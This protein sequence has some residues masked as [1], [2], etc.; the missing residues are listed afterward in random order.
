MKKT[1]SGAFISISLIAL[2]AI[3]VFPSCSKNPSS[4][5]PGNSATALWPLKAGNQWIYVDS[6]FSDTL[7]SSSNP[8]TVTALAQTYHDPSGFPL[9]QLTT[10]GQ[11]WFYNNSFAGVDPGN[12]AIFLMDTLGESS[13][14]FFATAP[15]D[16]T[17]VGSGADYTNPTCPIQYTQVGFA[18]T[19]AIGDYNCIRN[20]QYAT[21]CNGVNLEV[22]VV[23][24][25]PGVGVVRIEDYEADQNNNLGLSYSQTLKSVTLAK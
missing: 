24:V 15:Q 5:G 3:L 2:V 13:Y 20:V 10:T 8:D 4:S 17:V 12:D 21:D 9:Y 1:L 19:T 7:Y 11:G 14:L 18:S 22:I 6:L 23:Y 16:G 25:A